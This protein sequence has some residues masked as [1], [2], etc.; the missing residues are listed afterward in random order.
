VITLFIFISATYVIK[1]SINLCSQF[2]PFR[3]TFCF[4]NLGYCLIRL[5]S[6][7]RITVDYQGFTVYLHPLF[8]MSCVGIGLAN[9]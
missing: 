4:T 9:D 5:T 1:F 2:F 3:A 7:L 6:P 8:V